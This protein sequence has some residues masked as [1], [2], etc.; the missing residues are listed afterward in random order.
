MGG[1][2]KVLYTKKKDDCARLGVF[3]IYSGRNGGVRKAVEERWTGQWSLDHSLRGSDVM[4]GALHL[5]PLSEDTT[6]VQ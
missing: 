5:C 2:R 3:T 1:S 4:D 6:T